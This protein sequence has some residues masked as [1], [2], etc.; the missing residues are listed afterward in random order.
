MAN[1]P[2]INASI[3]MVSEY[4]G[5]MKGSSAHMSAVMVKLNFQLISCPNSEIRVIARQPY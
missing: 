5:R 3:R 1:S 2:K 4:C